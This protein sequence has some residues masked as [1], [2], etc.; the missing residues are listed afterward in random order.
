M[1]YNHF[2][3]QY[4]IIISVMKMFGSKSFAIE[5]NIYFH[6]DYICHWIKSLVSTNKCISIIL[7]IIIIVT[8][9]PA[10]YNTMIKTRKL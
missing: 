7:S 9:I 4:N 3:Y 1:G 2:E 10:N 6:F 8:L 5:A